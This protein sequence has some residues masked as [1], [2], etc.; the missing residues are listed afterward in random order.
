MDRNA[1]WEPAGGCGGRSVGLTIV[2]R[3]CRI[4][5]HVTDRTGVWRKEPKVWIVSPIR[6]KAVRLLQASIR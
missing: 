5:S 3:R 4:G 6:P 2:E 1:R